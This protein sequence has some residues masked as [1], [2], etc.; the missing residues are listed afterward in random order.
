[1]K[2]KGVLAFRIECMKETPETIQRNYNPVDFSE[3]AWEEIEDKI[4]QCFQGELL[5]Y[6]L[7][8]INTY[9]IVITITIEGDLDDFERNSIIP[10]SFTL[11]KSDEKC[12]LLIEDVK[13]L[14]CK[15]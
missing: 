2:T 6:E 15:R 14:W 3:E 8:Q 11:S 9:K 12:H 4:L 1:M 10:E 7:V 13:W 5:D